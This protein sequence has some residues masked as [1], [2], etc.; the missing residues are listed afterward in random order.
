MTTEENAEPNNLFEQC[1][2]DEIEA[3]AVL[4]GIYPVTPYFRDMLRDQSPIPRD[5]TIGEVAKIYLNAALHRIEVAHAAN[6][7]VIE[8]VAM[9]HLECAGENK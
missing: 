4:C 1:T 3:A 2:P 6:A 5:F 7:R 8:K 9:R